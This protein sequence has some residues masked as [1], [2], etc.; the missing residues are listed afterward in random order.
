MTYSRVW[1]AGVARLRRECRL[2]NLRSLHFHASRTEIK[3]LCMAKLSNTRGV[4][5]HWRRDGVKPGNKH[6]SW[7][8]IQTENQ[9]AR[10]AAIGELKDLLVRHRPVSVGAAS[11]NARAPR[12]LRTQNRT[13]S[14]AGSS[15]TTTAAIT[16]PP[17]APP[18]P[19]TITATAADAAITAAPIAL[20]P[21]P[22]TTAAA[23]SSSSTT[24]IV[25]PSS[26]E[27]AIVR[28][29]GETDEER[30]LVP[31]AVRSKDDEESESE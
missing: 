2:V 23:D 18:A 13:A 6:L 29:A 19:P 1:E 20:L 17:L 3:A 4:I 28:N 7:V 16:A 22:T 24:A 31:L 8:F 11:R 5:F 12:A 25:A 14:A 9:I 10:D 21:P 27:I 30:R 26:S 15:N